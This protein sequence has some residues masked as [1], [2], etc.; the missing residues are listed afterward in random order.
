VVKYMAR[1]KSSLQSKVEEEIGK[2]ESL[3]TQSS[4][5]ECKLASM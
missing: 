1:R 5:E 3:L 2:L 4:N